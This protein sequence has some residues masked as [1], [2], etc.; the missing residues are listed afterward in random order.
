MKQFFLITIV[1]L[2]VGCVSKPNT[3]INILI[4]GNGIS[5]NDKKVSLRIAI[6]K[7][8]CILKIEKVS[9]I[10]IIDYKIDDDPETREFIAFLKLLPNINISY[11]YLGG[12]DFPEK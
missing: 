9:R 1:L 11:S 5:V 7:I 2:V 10:N 6:E 12:S 4:Q 8:Q 3:E